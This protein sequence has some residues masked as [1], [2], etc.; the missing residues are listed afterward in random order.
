MRLEC[1]T[2]T[3]SLLSAAL[4]SGVTF[5][6]YTHNSMF[7]TIEALW[8]LFVL[9][10]RTT[11]VHVMFNSSRLQPSVQKKNNPETG[12]HLSFIITKS[13]SEVICLE[14]FSVR[15]CISQVHKGRCQRHR[16]NDDRWTSSLDLDSL[17]RQI[18]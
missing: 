13:A 2:C 4:M 5:R 8:A 18:S 10:Q 15:N 14:S 6:S 12:T 9:H 17:M 1:I 7:K 16:V 3:L 11:V